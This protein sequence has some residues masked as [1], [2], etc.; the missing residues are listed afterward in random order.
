MYKISVTFVLI[1]LFL[2][3]NQSSGQSG[4]L[5][6]EEGFAAEVEDAYATGYGNREMQTLFRYDFTAK[7]EDLVLLS[8]VLEY[9]L[10]PN[11]EVS[12]SV[13]IRMGSGDR[14][15]SGNI[16]L[17]GFYNFNSE[18]ILMPAFAAVFIGEIPTGFNSSGFDYGLKFIITKTISNKLD[19][20]H[21]NFR[22]FI[23]SDPEVEPANGVGPQKE[24]SAMIRAV[25]GYSGRFGP[26]TVL[27]ADYVYDQQRL[28]EK[29][30]HII[31]AGLR[32]Q[33]TPAMVI[34]L[35]LGVGVG[36]NS[37]Q[38]RGILGIQHVF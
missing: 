30:S 37:P 25:I 3:L 21:I 17:E 28:L 26:T 19:R 9:G 1:F 8:P 31:E 6:L 13:P 34:S 32:R 23:N 7:A 18:G 5:N 10:F 4:Q 38:F 15:G 27:V 22:Y 36:P 35:G 33:F 20:L 11:T 12:V 2:D 24:R 29:E 16:K 14:I